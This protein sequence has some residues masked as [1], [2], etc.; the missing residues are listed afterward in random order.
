MRVIYSLG[1]FKTFT[2]RGQTVSLKLYTSGHIP[3]L[4]GRQCCL[5]LG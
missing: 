2:V 5:A 3:T 1:A 4:C